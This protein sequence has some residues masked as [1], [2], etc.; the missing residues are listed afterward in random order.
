MAGPTSPMKLVSPFARLNDRLAGIAP[1]LPPIQLSLGEPQHPIP[2]FV[3]PTIAEHLGEFGR[4]PPIRGTEAFRISVAEWLGRRY[5]LQAPIDPDRMVLPL[6]GSREGLFFAAL[7]ARERSPAKDRPVV[8]LPNPFYQAYAAGAEAAGAE[9]VLVEPDEHGALP[10]LTAVPEAV[11]ARTIAV[12]AASPTNPQGSVATLEAWK[13][14]IE[15]ARRFDI[16][17]FADEC[18]SEIYRASPPPGVLEAAAALG[19]GYGNVLTFHSLS[20]RSNLPGLRCGFAA[21]D[22]DFIAGWVRLRNMA[23]PQVPGPLQAVAVA[24]YRDEGHVEMNRAL[25][26]E[27]FVLAETILGERLPGGAP[28][29]GFFLW[30]PVEDD[31]A[32]AE[33]LWREGGVR[34]IPGGYLCLPDEAGRNPGSKFLRVAM[35][36]DIDLTRE[37]LTRMARLLG[38][39]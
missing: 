4:Y 5:S 3:G 26:N 7:G 19:Q 39:S 24:A 38:R 20:K 33:L 17:I 22:P 9:I 37:A 11:L 16:M 21:G 30:L 8:L 29:G 25:Y 10:D 6:N 18:Y 14:L 15:T 31:E 1:G 2:A 27:K 32:A 12:Y 13:T 35:V 34:T 28:A 36:Q 23:A